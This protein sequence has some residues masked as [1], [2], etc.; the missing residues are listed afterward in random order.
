MRTLVESALYSH[1]IS[2]LGH[3]ERLD[4]ALMGLTWAISIM[5]EDFKIVPNTSMLRL[6]KSEEMKMDGQKV[7]IRIWFVIR[8]AEHVD[9]LAA[10]LVNA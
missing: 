2:R 9:L 5:A 4:D 10:D 3:V 8:D 6:V 7:R 1:N